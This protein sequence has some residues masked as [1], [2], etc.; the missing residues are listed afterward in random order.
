MRRLLP[1][2]L[3]LAASLA[4][5]NYAMAHDIKAGDLQIT[6]MWTRATPGS[7]KVAGGYFTV[8]NTGA[9]S[10][11]LVSATSPASGKVEVHEMSMA[12]GV[13]TMRPLEAGLVVE[14]GKSV[15]LAPGG[16]HMM[17]TDLKEPLKEGGLL[18]ITLQFEK[19]GKVEV[20]LHIRGVGAQGP[21]GAEKAGEEKGHDHAKTKM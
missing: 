19:A 4:S 6:S 11:R 10:D 16:F 14:A 15:T 13:M 1:S 7:A 8:T 17:L 3:V 9:A 20:T 12:N 2:L 21:G 18:P 5:F